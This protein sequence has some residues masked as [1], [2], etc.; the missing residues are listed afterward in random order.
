MGDIIYKPIIENMR[1]SY[2]RITTFSDCPFEWFLKYIE[3]NDDDKKYYASYGTAMHR[4]IDSVMSGKSDINN[5]EFDYLNNYLECISG[6]EKPED[7]IVQSYLRDAMNYTGS[8][9]GFPCEILQTEERIEF[10]YGGKS[11]VAIV[12]AVGKSDD[13][14]YIIDHKSKSLK[15]RSK[16]SA[17][18]KNDKE[19]DR[20]LRQLY[21][22]S[23]AIEK[24]Y[25]KLP[26]WLCINAFRSGEFIKEPFHKDVFDRTM[27]ELLQQIE[28]I[29][30]VES[31]PCRDEYFKCR[32]LCPVSRAC[33]EYWG[34]DRN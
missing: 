23:A 15:Q 12:D 6:C 26:D 32:W 9:S 8:F 28:Y 10:D 29:E 2:S 3:H 7:K 5:M 31:F 14:L 24:R 16:R 22:Y 1:W 34:D 30:N 18:T 19:I 4:T 13:G 27:E 17:P 20:I 11:F 21:L 25:G 33:D